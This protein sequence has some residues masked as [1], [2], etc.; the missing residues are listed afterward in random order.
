MLLLRRVSI[1][2]ILCL[3]RCG[4]YPSR[5]FVVLHHQCNY[6]YTLFQDMSQ[7]NH[8]MI[9]FRLSFFLDIET[10]TKFVTSKRTCNLMLLG[11]LAIIFLLFSNWLNNLFSF[12][13]L[14]W[15]H[16]EILFVIMFFNYCLVTSS[17][18]FVFV[19]DV[20]IRD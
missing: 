12:F 9:V 10:S 6:H 14:I 11:Y 3:C 4:L 16:R 20:T 1:A 17:C 7:D 19:W 8:I 15:Y 2:V 18:G 13:S 5:K